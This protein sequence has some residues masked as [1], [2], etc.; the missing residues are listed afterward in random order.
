MGVMVQERYGDEGVLQAYYRNQTVPLERCE[1]SCLGEELAR[2]EITQ[3]E[4]GM[5]C[6]S[7]SPSA[8]QR[9]VSSTAA[10][11]SQLG[12]S[13]ACKMRELHNRNPVQS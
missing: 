10:R 5:K 3:P 2:H 1:K 11:W 7:C 13:R 6:R 9:R 8:T 4:N 12:M